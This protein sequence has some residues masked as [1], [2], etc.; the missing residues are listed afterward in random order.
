MTE[1]QQPER[2][3]EAAVVGQVRRRINQAEQVTACKTIGTGDKKEEVNSTAT[4]G[5]EG[6]VWEVRW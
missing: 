5:R 2:S 3:D 1:L 4:R 6:R